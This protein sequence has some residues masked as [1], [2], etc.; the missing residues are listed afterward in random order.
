MFTDKN[1]GRFVLA[2]DQSTSASKVM[3]FGQ[4][5]KLIT[6]ISKAHVQTYPQP[7]FVEHDP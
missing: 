1:K 7:G 5:A 3:L 4:D 2:I 6:R